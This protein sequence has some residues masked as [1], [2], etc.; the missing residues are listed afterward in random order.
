MEVFIKQDGV[1]NCKLRFGVS[2][3]LEKNSVTHKSV[4]SCQGPAHLALY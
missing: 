4:Y 2:T 1:T 3:E